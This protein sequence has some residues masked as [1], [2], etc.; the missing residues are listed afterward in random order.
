MVFSSLTFL[1]VFLPAVLLLYSL[2]KNITYK[3]TVLAVFSLTFYAWGEPIMVL[4]LVLTTLI[5]YLCALAMEK[6]ASAALKKLPFRMDGDRDAYMEK[7][8]LVVLM[9]FTNWL[10][11][12]ATLRC[13]ATPVITVGAIFA[14]PTFLLQLLPK[15]LQPL[16]QRHRRRFIA[17]AQ[18]LQRHRFPS[19][20]S[21]GNAAPGH[22]A[23]SRRQCRIPRAWPPGD[24][25]TGCIRSECT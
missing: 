5:N 23:R 2:S 3:N 11:F 6:A 10:R 7:Y 19:S 24:R 1:C 16:P 8:L 4:L 18:F 15:L 13:A 17:K 14:V 21:A 25:K 20:R 12:G 22:T 9:F